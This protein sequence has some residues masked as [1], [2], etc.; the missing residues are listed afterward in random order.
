MYIYIHMHCSIYQVSALHCRRFIEQMQST[1]SKCRLF[2]QTPG[3]S[4][5]WVTL[6]HFFFSWSQ[7][8]EPFSSSFLKGLRLD[9]T[10]S[11][12]WCQSGPT[13]YC[14][15]GQRSFYLTSLQLNSVLLKLGT[16]P[17]FYLMVLALG[18]NEIIRKIY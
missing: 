8:S 9:R 11:K 13:M 16:N 4:T 18:L 10:T 5:C 17:S 2:L 1:A 3:H 14:I 7:C 15:P 6:E 12:S